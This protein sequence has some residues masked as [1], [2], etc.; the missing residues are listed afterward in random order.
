MIWLLFILFIIQMFFAFLYRYRDLEP[1][2][3]AQTEISLP[4]VTVL[5]CAK[6]E[7]KN[8]SEHLPFFINQDYPEAWELLIV[9]DAST[10]ETSRVLKQFQA[11]FTNI[12][13]LN[14]NPND[15]RVFPGKKHALYRGLKAA[16][17]NIIIL[18]DAD[19]F[20]KSNQ[21]ILK[22]ANAYK[23]Q[24]FKMNTNEVF[25]LGYGAYER[26][27]GLLNRF[28]CWE[29]LHTFIQYA[30]WAK[31]GLPYMGVGRNL[32]YH[33]GPV[34][35]LLDNDEDFKNQFI[36]SAS[37]DDDLIVSRLA[38]IE[39]TIVCDETEAQTV[40][41]SMKSWQ[42]WW[43]QKTR[44]VSSGKYYN[45]I[46]KF[47]LGLYAL[48]AFLFWVIS[49]MLLF[50]IPELIGQISLLLLSI[51]II[52]F[53]LNGFFWSKRLKENRIIWF[54]PIGEL[55][56]ALFNLVVSPYIFWKNKKRWK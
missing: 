31:L 1:N 51:R 11:S 16:Q 15:Q 9:N 34:L 45:S 56:W 8:L 42:K 40:S 22:M 55:M 44:H 41:K 38:N 14:I 6:N 53:W 2:E 54:Y 49:F 21:W 26:T 17:N 47:G 46:S 50:K 27:G 12:N 5:I 23:S 3:V 35:E 18:S 37:G 24:S 39:N 52:A 10:D 36:K 33:R 4:K 19:C 43:Q 20:P 28:I 25:V 29:T 32:M 48:S 7:A 30:S 13:I